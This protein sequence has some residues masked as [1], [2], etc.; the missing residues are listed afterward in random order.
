MISIVQIEKYA[1]EICGELLSSLQSSEW[2]C[3][4][5]ASLAVADFAGHIYSENCCE[6]LE[7]I[8]GLVFRICDDIKVSKVKE[9]FSSCPK[10]VILF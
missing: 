6:H 9:M 5:A 1:P 8:W 2:R 4:E 7:E 10:D 3:R